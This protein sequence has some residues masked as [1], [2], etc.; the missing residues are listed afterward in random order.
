MTKI[1]TDREDR[2]EDPLKVVVRSKTMRNSKH[3]DLSGRSKVG[4]DFTKFDQIVRKK[5]NT[6]EHWRSY[7]P[8]KQTKSYYMTDIKPITKKDVGSPTTFEEQV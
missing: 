8:N 7:L 1:K 6:G 4:N 3:G 5:K 2:S